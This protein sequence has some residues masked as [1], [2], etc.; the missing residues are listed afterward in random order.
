MH[1]E[2]AKLRRRARGWVAGL[3]GLGLFLSAGTAQATGLFSAFITEFG[4][5]ESF[6]IRF[7]N[8]ASSTLDIIEIVLDGTAIG[9]ADPIVWTALGLAIEPPGADAVLSGKDTS[10]YTIDFV[11]AADGFNPTEVFRLIL[12][13]AG[14]ASN[15]STD[16]T[17]ADLAGLGVSVRFRDD[18]VATAE[19]VAGGGGLGAT[20]IP[21]PTTALMLLAGLVGLAASQR[22]G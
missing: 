4:S 18:S 14:L 12:T 6:D 22:W 13:G 20:N 7:V 15:P 19:F 2:V 10:T 3:A 5:P 21:E 16:V 11:D 9:L 1:A 17:V 8:D